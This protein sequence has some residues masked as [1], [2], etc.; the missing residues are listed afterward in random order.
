MGREC[1][2]ILLNLNLSEEDYM[3]IDSCLAALEN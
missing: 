1:L 2:Q 3:K